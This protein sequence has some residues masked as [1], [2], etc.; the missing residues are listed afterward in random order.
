M[1]SMVGSNS[2]GDGTEAVPAVVHAVVS[3]HAALI[4]EITEALTKAKRWL[5]NRISE[6]LGG[7]SSP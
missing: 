7:C 6:R 4:A 3:S 1:S 2:S 5:A